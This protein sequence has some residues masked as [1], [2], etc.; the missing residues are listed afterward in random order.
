MAKAPVLTPRAHDFPRWYQDLINKAELADNGPVRGTMVIRPYGYALWERMQAEMDARIKQA[1][2]ANAYF[3]LFIPQSYLTREA[4]HVE[5]FAPELAVVTHG[6]G[7]ELEEPVV[8]RPTSETIINDYFAKWVQSYRDLPLLIN[9]WANVVRW[10]MRPRVFLRTTE[11]LWQEGHTAH[12]TYEDARDY[13]AHIH[14]EVY[15]DF[16]VD[17]LGI[18]VVLGRKTASERFAGA[19]NTLTLEA[20]MGDGKALQMGTSH[21]LGQNFAKAFHT[22]YLSKEGREEYVWQTS[23]GSSTRMVGGLIMAHGDDD[24]LRVPPRLAPIQ[25]VVLAIKGDEPVLAKVREIGARLA[26]AGIRVQV[27]DRTDTPFGRRA[28]DWELKGVP[29]RIEVGPRDLEGGTAMLVRRI[30]GGTSQAFGTGGGKEPVPLDALTGLLP[31]ILDEDQALLLRQSR[32]RRESRT[33]DVSTVEEA[34]EAVTAGGWARVPWATLG[35]E[36][37]ARLAEQAV[38]VRCLVAEDGSVPDADDAPGNVAVVA[39]AY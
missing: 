4:E 31:T 26:A 5:G 33:S 29:I 32:E 10:E 17:V 37:E 9:Q 21:E 14:K 25:A 2:A 3:P 23:W 12:A 27:D 39:R 22:R 13:A 16:M 28:V 34:V 11:F 1:G 24:G 36:G 6:G 38:T 18:D 8:V 7:K 15:A 19:V 35:E 30:P 20:M